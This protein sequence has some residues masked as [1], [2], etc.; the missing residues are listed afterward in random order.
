MH[1]DNRAAYGLSLTA[2]LLGST[3]LHRHEPTSV[4]AAG[5]CV[6]SHFGPVEADPTHQRPQFVLDPG[7]G[8]IHLDYWDSAGRLSTAPEATIIPHDVPT[9]VDDYLTYEGWQFSANCPEADRT[10]IFQDH[11]A[12]SGKKFRDINDLFFHRIAKVADGQPFEYP[13][14]KFECPKPMQIGPIS[15]DVAHNGPQTILESGQSMLVQVIAQDTKGDQLG[16]QTPVMALLEGRNAAYQVSDQT[17]LTAFAY[18]GRCS[19]EQVQTTMAQNNPNNYQILSAEQLK[20]RGVLR[21]LPEVAFIDPTCTTA[22]P[23]GVFEKPTEFSAG[24]G[25]IQLEMFDAVRLNPNKSVQTM[26]YRGEAAKTKEGTVGFAWKFPRDCSS[27]VAYHAIGK[28]IQATQDIF[29]RAVDLVKDCAEG[30]ISNIYV[31][32]GVL[33]KASGQRTAFSHTYLS[34]MEGGHGTR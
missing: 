13:Q 30:Q 16:S 22:Q 14:P 8:E 15:A 3:V 32:C 6:A 28:S 19:Q 20:Q 5:D 4:Q 11:L 12:A 2:L 23:L 34:L 10:K 18:D 24:D 21:N 33:D 26:L 31:P 1:I 9:Q 27:Q 17:N 29:R 7:Q 25:I